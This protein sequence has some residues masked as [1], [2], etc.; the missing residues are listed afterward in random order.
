[1][2]RTFLAGARLFDGTGAPALAGALVVVAGGRVAWAGA[3]TA[4]AA[5][6]PAPGDRVVDLPDHTLL[7]GL[8]NVHVHLGLKRPFP[9]RRFD[10]YPGG[11]RAM[12]CYRRA[13]EALLG[14]TTTLRCLGEPHFA[15]ID[16]RDAIA[17]GML[18]GP[19]ILS[20]GHALT[21]TGGHWHESVATLEGDGAVELRRLARAQLRAGA[22]LVKVMATGGLGSPRE[23]LA[24]R[25]LAADEIAAAVDA[26]HAA[27]RRVAAHAAASGAIRECVR[28][29]VDSIEH[30]YSLDDE[31]AAL[32]AAAG[33]TLVPTLAV[34]RN[35]EMKRATG[36][37]AWMIERAR[38]AAAEHL[39]SV[40]RAARAGV[41]IA[42]GS[43]LL[44]SDAVDGTTGTVFEIEG[45]VLAGL[46]PP[47]ALQAATLNAA[48]LCGTD[49]VSGTLTAG[50]AAD[51]V[52]V[53]GCPDRAIGDL[54]RI[55]LVLKDGTVVRSA[56]PG[57]P[58]DLCLP[59]I[60]PGAPAFD[61]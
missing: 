21:A 11:T 23:R 29:G 48:R 25:Q 2:T 51:L 3:A 1:V 56:I 35:L 12:L 39:A 44:P 37:P 22:D 41:A 5:P 47:A 45:L 28:L 13:L 53:R 60:E 32:M 19:R 46:T 8:H 55:E 4:A 30:G 6:R 26:A 18:P 61:V 52:A 57:L 40:G 14:G 43:D 7:P 24:D 38:D 59:S 9:E 42:C 16:V 58:A 36:A 49:A 33:T 15:D 10:P 54:R 50:K 34:T 17:R 27:G 31:T 20:A